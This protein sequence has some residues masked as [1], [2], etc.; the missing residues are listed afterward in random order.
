MHWLYRRCVLAQISR[1]IGSKIG[2]NLDAYFRSVDQY[3]RPPTYKH[4]QGHFGLF[5]VVACSQ[6]LDAIDAD[7]GLTQDIF[8]GKT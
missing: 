7:M 3:R 2:E 4:Q 1:K 8:E 6:T 5:S